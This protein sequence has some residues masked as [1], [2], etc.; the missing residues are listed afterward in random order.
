MVT[1]KQTCCQARATACHNG[2]Q[3]S[4]H[5]LMLSIS[6]RSRCSGRPGFRAVGSAPAPRC[7]LPERAAAVL[8]GLSVQSI[9]TATVEARRFPSVR[10]AVCFKGTGCSIPSGYGRSRGKTPPKA[11]QKRIV[12]HCSRALRD[13]RRSREA[14]GPRQP[15]RRPARVSH[16]QSCITSPLAA[17]AGLVHGMSR[18]NTATS[19][20]HSPPQTSPG[21]GDQ[22]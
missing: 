20:R 4:G 10:K 12:S 8:A 5:A 6:T 3:F 18:R 1:R 22:L 19:R 15:L 2:H 16:F 9:A 13:R 11:S 21:R 17:L 14:R 7:R